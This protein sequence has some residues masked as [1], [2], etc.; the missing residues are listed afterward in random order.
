MDEALLKDSVFQVM[1]LVERKYDKNIRMDR[2]DEI[3]KEGRKCGDLWVSDGYKYPQHTQWP[4]RNY[5]PSILMGGRVGKVEV[6][7]I[8]ARCSSCSRPGQ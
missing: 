6:R 4:S 3:L 8:V 5:H 2:K 7:R 1:L